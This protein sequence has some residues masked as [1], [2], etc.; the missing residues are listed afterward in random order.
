M[1]SGSYAQQYVNP[2]NLEAAE[3]EIEMFMDLY[4][5]Y[6]KHSFAIA[7]KTTCHYHT[8]PSLC[9]QHPCKLSKQMYTPKIP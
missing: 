5:R 8:N 6:A 1:W 4:N 9:S 7:M 3:Q 2:Q